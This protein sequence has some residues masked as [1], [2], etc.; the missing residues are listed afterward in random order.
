MLRDDLVTLLQ[1][2]LGNRTDL[3]DRI[4]LE[5]ALVQSFILEGTGAFQPWFLESE[6]SRIDVGPGEER[7]AL[8][9]DFLG[10]I[11]EQS[12]WLYDED[13]IDAPYTEL[14]KSS[15]DKL[16]LKHQVA[17]VPSE[18]AMVGEYI[19][20]R[21]IPDDIYNIRMRYYAAAT[22][23]STGNIENSWLKHASDWVMAETG[24]VI[25]GKHIRNAPL[26]EEFRQEAAIARQR[27]Y[28]KHEARKHTN[29]TYGM[30]ED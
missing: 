30:G 12:L 19:L 2:R 9:T 4:I 22:S 15:Y 14:H 23:V 5:M 10:E 24:A 6:M 13:N 20:L 17:G 1:Y 28:T 3:E 8:P 11:E 26:A 18:Y 29:R 21:P 7:V 16:I 25:A 27:V